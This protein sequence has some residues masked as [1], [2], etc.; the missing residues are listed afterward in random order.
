MVE[1][2]DLKYSI[3]N[4]NLEIE[5]LKVNKNERVAIVGSNGSGKSTLL[6]FITGICK[7][8]E[9]EIVNSSE[10]M[11]YC[12][13]ENA[14][15]TSLTLEENLIFFSKI[16]GKDDLSGYMEEIGISS[17]DLEKN[18][19]ENYLIG[20]K[21]LIAAALMTDFDLL[22]LDEPTS[23]LDPISTQ[24]FQRKLNE[25]LNEKEVTL[26]LVTHCSKEAKNM[27]DR[28]IYLED[29]KLS[30]KMERVEEHQPLEYKLE[31]NVV[32][33]D[34]QCAIIAL[35]EIKE[36]VI[37]LKG[38][39]INEEDSLLIFKIS[40]TDISEELLDVMFDREDISKAKLVPWV[41]EANN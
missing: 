23:W 24:M 25:I 34:K 8:E 12:P 19:T 36:L 10:R 15:F 11:F 26:I 29:G 17:Y 30:E 20:R 6:R 16:L 37:E 7:S 39:L 41:I 35:V 40:R 33:K 28:V 4:F 27:T 13:Q 3:G 14:A 32:S 38:K 22:V 1:I 18:P 9:G 5:R 2:D 31:L 21:L